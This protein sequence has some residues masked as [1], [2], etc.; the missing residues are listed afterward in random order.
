MPAISVVMPVYN[1]K[2]Y[3]AKA[4]QSILD[5]T[6]SD[7]EFLIIDNGSTDGSGTIINQFAQKDARIR[8][9]RNEKNVFIAEARNRALAQAKGEYLYLIDS[10]DWVFPDMLEVMYGRAK[11]FDAQYVVAGYYMDYFVNGKNESYAVCPDDRDY[12]QQEF[13]ENAIRYLVHTILTVPWNKLYSIA[14]LREHNIA[15]RNTKLEDHHFNM[16]IIMDVERVSMVSRPFYHYYR[17][18]QGTDS[19][20]VYNQ[21]LNQKKRDHIAHTLAVYEHWG[22]QDK[23]TLGQLADYH[24]GRLIQCVMQTVANKQLSKKEKYIELQKIADDEYTAFATKNALNQ[25]KKIALMSIPIRMKNV[26]LCYLMGWAI[27]KFKEK[28]SG[29]YYTMRA[30]VAQ[31]AIRVENRGK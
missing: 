30:S 25:S 21:F 19:E 24:L 16:D 18:R 27:A 8:V 4:I 23:N 20:L 26:K 7:F 12:Q 17:S 13:R 2:D 22:I 3:V 9:I 5:Q 1:T 14:Y 11:R 10:D 28:F 6:F 15:F 29:V 31:G